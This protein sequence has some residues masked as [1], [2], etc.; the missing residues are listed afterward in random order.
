M[1]TLSVMNLPAT[2][3]VSQELALVFL[4]LWTA[5]F[6]GMEL[7]CFPSRD[8]AESCCRWHFAC[9]MCLEEA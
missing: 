4:S 3:T 1:K 5:S 9:Q 8:M 6:D 7:G 2:Y